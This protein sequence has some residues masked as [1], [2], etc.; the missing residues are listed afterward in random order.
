MPIITIATLE[1]VSKKFEILS[2]GCW[3]WIGSKTRSHNGYG[4]IKVKNRNMLA[5]RVTYVAFNG[6]VPSGLEIDHMCKN[7]T[8]V[9]PKHLESVTASEN[10]RRGSLVQDKS[11]CRNGHKYPVGVYTNCVKCKEDRQTTRMGKELV[12]KA[13]TV[14]RRSWCKRGHKLDGLNLYIT[15]NNRRQCKTCGRQ[16]SIEYFKRVKELSHV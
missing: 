16:R 3:N 15:P 11:P 4:Q 6:N 9:N 13:I 10:V 1:R 8:C 5:H 14:E 7:R 12:R 2:T